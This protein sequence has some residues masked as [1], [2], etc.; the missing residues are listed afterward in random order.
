MPFAT[1]VGNCGGDDSGTDVDAAANAAVA[2]ADAAATGAADLPPILSLML[3][4]L[5]AMSLMMSAK[6]APH[7]QCKKVFCFYFFVFLYP[8]HHLISGVQL[9]ML[10][11]SKYLRLI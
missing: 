5:L 1:G 9:L 10:C 4:L 6:L 11:S 3:V 7:N 2:A 8:L